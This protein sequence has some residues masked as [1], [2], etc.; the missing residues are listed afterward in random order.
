M[1]FFLILFNRISTHKNQLNKLITTIRTEL[2]YSDSIIKPFKLLRLQR[3]L[4][5]LKINSSPKLIIN[6]AILLYT[7]NDW[8]LKGLCL[9][10][11]LCSGFSACLT[12][13]TGVN[14]TFQNERI[15]VIV[16]L[17]NLFLKMREKNNF[18]LCHLITK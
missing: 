18:F 3:M 17:L 11:S 2:H 15:F 16:E 1:S 12:S 9:N 10:R 4:G 6:K 5:Q 14:S 13:I 8:I 7:K